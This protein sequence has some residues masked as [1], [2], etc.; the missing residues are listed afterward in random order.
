MDLFQNINEVLKR[1]TEAQ[2]STLDAINLTHKELRKNIEILVNEINVKKNTD[3]L[4]LLKLRFLEEAEKNLIIG[5]KSLMDAIEE[6][7]KSIIQKVIDET[8]NK[9]KESVAYFASSLWNSVWG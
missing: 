9:V 7:K 2:Q 3:P 6:A 4:Q 8:T 1:T 5:K